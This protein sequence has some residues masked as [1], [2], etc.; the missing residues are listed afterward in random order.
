VLQSAVS[1][2][3]DMTHCRVRSVDRFLKAEF[4]RQIERCVLCLG[5]FIGVLTQPNSWRKRERR[6]GVG[7]ATISWPKGGKE[8]SMAIGHG[9]L[10]SLAHSGLCSSSSVGQN[11]HPG[12]LPSLPILE[13][14]VISQRR[15]ILRPPPEHVRSSSVRRVSLSFE[16]AEVDP[17]YSNAQRS[18]VPGSFLPKLHPLPIP[19]GTIGLSWRPTPV[20][21]TAKLSLLRGF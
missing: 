19:R 16:S 5:V 9:W 2:S 17:R 20:F 3:A 7:R 8:V 4:K 14:I 18:S 10:I 12:R 11:L 13:G 21:S 1:L 6:F 15:A